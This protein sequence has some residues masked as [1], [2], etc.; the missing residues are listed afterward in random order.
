MAPATLRQLRDEAQKIYGEYQARFAGKPRATR[1]L[2]AL[3]DIIGR[4]EEVVE[5]ARKLQNG[6]QNPALSSFIEQA[7]ENLETYE[8]EREGIARAK[9]RGPAAEQA[10]RLATWANLFF[11][12]YLR[13]FA[14]KNRATRD[15]GLLNEIISELEFV[16]TQMKKVIADKGF[17]STQAD[18]QTVQNNLQL[19][20][21]ERAEIFSSRRDATLEQ[22][23][24]YLAVVANEQFAIY[25]YHFAGK[26]RASRRPG[27]LHRVIATL[28]SVRDEM[29]EIEDEGLDSEQNRQ[30]RDI[31]DQKLELYEEEFEQIQKV[32]RETSS[33]DLVGHLGQAANAAAQQYSEHFAGEDR[34]SRN[35]ELLSRICDELLDVGRQMRQLKDSFDSRANDKNLIIVLDN[36]MLYQGEFEKIREVQRD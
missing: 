19:Y 2:E 25:D 32:R 33:S 1:D 31:I 20:R 23:A 9:S 21:D 17:E 4:L 7:V 27:L 36:A 22:R 10:G 8:K 13:H 26:P 24:S 3:D 12:Q 14:G 18:L 30:N 35:L 11:G 5:G 28:E 6:G 29:A 16:E 34:A 15:V